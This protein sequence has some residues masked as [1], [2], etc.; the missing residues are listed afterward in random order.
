MGKKLWGTV[1]VRKSVC[2]EI[3]QWG[4]VLVGKSD[5][6]EKNYEELN[7]G[8]T[9]CEEKCVGKRP[10]G[11]K[12][13]GEKNRGEKTVG[14]EVVGKRPLTI[15]NIIL[16]WIRTVFENVNFQGEPFRLFQVHFSV[17]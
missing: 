4:N 10:S 11:E 5:C 15:Q 1:Y 14:K 17:T 12:V 13:C 8:E 7:C 3:E 16:V 9:K 6:E 2:E